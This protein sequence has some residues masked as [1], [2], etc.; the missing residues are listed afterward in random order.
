VAAE[1]GVIC[2]FCSLAYSRSRAKLDLC[3]GGGGS[4]T[5][6]C[7]EPNTGEIT[8]SEKCHAR[9]RTTVLTQSST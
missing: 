4:T 8:A 6:K 9:F 1:Q 5:R 2:G 3:R 7:R